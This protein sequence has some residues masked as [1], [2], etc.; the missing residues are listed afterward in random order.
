MGKALKDVNIDNDSFKGV[1]A[2]IRSMTPHERHNPEV[3]N[4]SRRQRIATGSG[5]TVLEVNRLLKQFDDMRR[6]M[7][8]MPAARNSAPSG[9]GK[10]GRR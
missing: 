3:I 6:M 5:T 10:K 4:G 9:K 2:M 7:G 1:E 8:R